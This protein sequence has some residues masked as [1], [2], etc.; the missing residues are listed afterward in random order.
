MNNIKKLSLYCLDCVK[1]CGRSS[2]FN[3]LKNGKENKII[4]TSDIEFDADNKEINEIMT[5]YAL[6]KSTMGIFKGCL[7]LEGE[8]KKE[9][10]YSPLL[11][12]EAELIREGD[13]IRLEY[14]EDNMGVNVCLIAAL[15]ENDADIVEN[16]INELLNIENLCQIDFKKVLS[17]LINLNDLEIK[18][19]NAIILAKT[20]ESIA[21][22]V[23]ELKVIS[24]RYC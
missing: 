19:E 12:C 20:P 17:G 3:N 13:K 24:E 5:K 8:R 7:M 18:E 11:Y 4:I 22:L 1:A 6:N 21:G 15:L 10:F 9:R 23:N 2:A 16:T 14:D